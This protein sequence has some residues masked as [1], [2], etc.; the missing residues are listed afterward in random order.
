MP[1]D[2]SYQMPK[3]EKKVFELLPDDVYEVKVKDIEK[4]VSPF[5]DDDGNEREVFK[6]TFSVEEQAFPN[7]LVFKEVSPYAYISKKGPSVLLS[8]F[9]AVEKRDL[10]EE[11]A[12]AIGSEKVNALIGKGLRVNLGH[13]TSAAGNE[14]N[15]VK[16]FLPSKLVPL[17]EIPF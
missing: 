9:N 16:G 3:S 15:V 1:I 14:Y 12:S 17:S 4:I 8:I 10:T 6:F 13:K 2:T 7:R 11:E 5:K